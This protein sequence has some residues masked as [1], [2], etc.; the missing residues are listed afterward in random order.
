METLYIP[1]PK[2]AAI[3][4]LADR[5]HADPWSAH[6]ASRYRR[7]ASWCRTFVVR[8]THIRSD[9]EGVGV[10]GIEREGADGD[11]GKVAADV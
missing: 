9:V 3:R 4:R 7:L 8:K 1:R 11:V 5:S 6:W 10:H 2:V